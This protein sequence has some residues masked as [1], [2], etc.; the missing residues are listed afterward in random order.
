MELC[1]GEGEGNEKL[2]SED[3]WKGLKMRMGNRMKERGGAEFVAWEVEEKNEGL[4]APS[5]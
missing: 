1:N 4:S 3:T 2:F 5:G